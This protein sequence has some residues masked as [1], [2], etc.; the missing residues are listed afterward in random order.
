MT[1]T[2]KLLK[3]PSRKSRLNVKI[4]SPFSALKDQVSFNKMIKDQLAH[5]VA[6]VPLVENA[7]EV[8]TR[9]GKTTR[10]LPYPNHVRTK[11]IPKEGEDR[12]DESL[13]M[14]EPSQAKEKADKP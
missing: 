5:L 8:V 12:N 7:K 1:K 2:P 13:G 11:K 6:F 14:R 9:G 3:L 4:D 10:D